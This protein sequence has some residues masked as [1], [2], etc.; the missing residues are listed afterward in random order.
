ME[1]APDNRLP[2]TPY[3]LSW[4]RGD[5]C[6]QLNQ[7]PAVGFHWLNGISFQAHPRGVGLYVSRKTGIC[8]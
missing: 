2:L 4:L 5:P 8:H 6:K 7:N 3:G 1:W